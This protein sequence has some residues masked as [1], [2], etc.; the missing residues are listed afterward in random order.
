MGLCGGRFWIYGL[1]GFLGKNLCD[2]ERHRRDI[3]VSMRGIEEVLM[4][5]GE[6]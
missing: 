2:I 4:S 3:Y 1:G 6:S 5:S